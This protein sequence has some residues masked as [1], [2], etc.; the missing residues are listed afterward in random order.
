MK[1]C[2]VRRIGIIL[3]LAL[4]MVTIAPARLRAD[5]SART[6]APDFTAKV[7]LNSPPTRLSRLRGKVVLI[8]FW[9]YT[10]INCIRTFPALRRWNSLYGPLGLVTI[11]VH[12][13]EF[14][15][16]KDDGRVA[17]AVKRF[18]LTFPIA[19]D[20]DYKIWD[21]F[22]NEAWPAKYLIDKDG[23]IAF[24]HLGEGQYTEFETQIQKLLAEANPRLDFTGPKFAMP[25]PPPEPAAG[26]AQETPE[27][28]LGFERGDHLVNESGYQRLK[29]ASYT[30]P[31]DIPQNGYAL[32]GR[33]I[34]APESIEHPAGPGGADNSVT[35]RYEAKSVY[36]VAGSEDGTVKTL[37]VTQ[38]GKPVAKNAMGV[39]LKPGVEGRTSAALTGKRMYYLIDNPGFGPHALKLTAA[40]APLSLYSF[41]FGNDCESAF[42]H[43]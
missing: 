30:A 5:D 38:D 27:T 36:L 3:I 34:A 41:T 43:R 26:C 18:G 13:P 10:C 15:F 33:W 40:A 32:N 12:T 11:G 35:L 21:A 14:A 9:E 24:V 42:D 16:A 37:E 39:D 29:P 31:A 2:S 20:S 23:N 19:V 4:A 22:H 8:D 17:E 7:W 28:Y 25:Q 6:P 1:T